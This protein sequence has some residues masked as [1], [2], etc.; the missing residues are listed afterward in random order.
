MFDPHNMTGNVRQRPFCSASPKKA[1]LRNRTVKVRVLIISCAPC[2]RADAL[3]SLLGSARPV[4]F[5]NVAGSIEHGIPAGNPR[6][7]TGTICRRL[8]CA[9][10]KTS[11]TPPSCLTDRRALIAL[12]PDDHDHV[13]QLALFRELLSLPIGQ[14][15]QER[16]GLLPPCLGSAGLTLNSDNPTATFLIRH[17]HVVPCGFLGL[18]DRCRTWLS[19]GRVI[20]R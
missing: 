8:L 7:A 18:T 13:E 19:P 1:G 15:G 5:G 4:Q 12:A 14:G 9:R 20:R 3:S 10:V 17:R 6:S 2:L 16:L 11:A